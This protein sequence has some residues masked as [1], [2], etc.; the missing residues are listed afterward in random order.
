MVNGFAYKFVHGNTDHVL[1]H[2]DGSVALLVFAIPMGEWRWG[3]V[4]GDG[5]NGACR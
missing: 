2:N 3:S 5:E 4:P 1:G